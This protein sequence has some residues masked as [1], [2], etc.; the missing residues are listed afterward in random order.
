MPALASE[1]WASLRA[2]MHGLGKGDARRVLRRAGCVRMAAIGPS[3][4]RERHGIKK[5]PPAACVANG[6]R[7]TNT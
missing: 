4:R 7:R 5:G 2:V 1:H 3:A 6:M